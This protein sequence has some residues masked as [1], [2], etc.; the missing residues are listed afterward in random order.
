[1]LGQAYPAVHGGG[2]QRGLR[3]EIGPGAANDLFPLLTGKDGRLGGEWEWL[4]QMKATNML[5]WPVDPVDYARHLRELP[6]PTNGK[7]YAFKTRY[8]VALRPGKYP[9]IQPEGTMREPRRAPEYDPYPM[10]WGY[11]SG[12]RGLANKY[13]V[14]EW[15][16]QGYT[17]WPELEA[18]QHHWENES[19]YAFQEASGVV[20][21]PTP[22]ASQGCGGCCP[23]TWGLLCPGK[24]PWTTTGCPA[25]YGSRGISWNGGLPSRPMSST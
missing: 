25:G 14:P 17:P 21:P 3:R 15:A 24:C 4:V 10:T 13:R 9:R 12:A 20:T 18:L 2:A 22:C 19:R 7:T 8:T 6:D 11:V 16:Q 5:Y 23:S 1:M